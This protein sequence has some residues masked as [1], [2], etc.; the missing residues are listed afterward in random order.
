M[1]VSRSN[2]FGD[3][4]EHLVSSRFAKEVRRFRRELKDAYGHEGLPAKICIA[5][6]LACMQMETVMSAYSQNGQMRGSIRTYTEFGR[7]VDVYVNWRTQLNMYT[8]D[9]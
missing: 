7:G 2:D 1:S 6:A 5:A 8:I 9:P 3:P 4:D